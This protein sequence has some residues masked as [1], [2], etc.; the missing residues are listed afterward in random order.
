[1]RVIHPPIK[2]LKEYHALVEYWQRIGFNQLKLKPYSELSARL[3]D[4]I[5]SAM[6]L[7]TTLPATADL[8]TIQSALEAITGEYPIGSN[9]RSMSGHYDTLIRH[10]S[11]SDL[12]SLTIFFLNVGDPALVISIESEWNVLYDDR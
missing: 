4:D 6:G 7:R 12:I 1:M 5:C 11:I 8:G 2:T 3:R 9:I 10:E